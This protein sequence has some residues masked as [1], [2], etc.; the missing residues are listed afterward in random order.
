MFSIVVKD[1]FERSRIRFVR[2]YLGQTSEF[3]STIL[4]KY[5]LKGESLESIVKMVSD[6]IK[7]FEDDDSDDQMLTDEMSQMSF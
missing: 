6:Y 1:M 3:L 5:M 2:C 7:R 4:R